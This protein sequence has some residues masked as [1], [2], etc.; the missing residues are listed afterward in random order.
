MIASC[1]FGQFNPIQDVCFSSNSV[2]VGENTHLLADLHQAA[3]GAAAGTWA[4]WAAH[5]F[6][7]PAPHA[8]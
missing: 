3:W 6:E 5:S 2:S 8:L 1:V 4:A 7:G